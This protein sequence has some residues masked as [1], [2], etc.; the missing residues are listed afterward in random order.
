M[1][2]RGTPQDGWVLPKAFKAFLTTAAA[3][4]LVGSLN[5]APSAEQKA[6]FLKLA[7]DR[8]LFT[9]Q[10]AFFCYVIGSIGYT[11]LTPRPADQNRRAMIRAL[12]DSNALWYPLRYSAEYHDPQ[13]HSGTINQIIHYHFPSPHD[14]AQILGLNTFRDFGGGNPYNAAFGFLDQNPHNTMHIWTGGMNPDAGAAAYVCDGA[15]PSAAAA[16]AAA[17]GERRNAMVH[18]AGRAFHTREDMYTQ[19]AQSS[20]C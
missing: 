20:S 3:E 18:A 8:T 14:M 13:G 2:D 12:V 1:D 11:H 10:H 19:P 15:P 4:Q 17:L 5:P 6:A 7:E 16:T 9:T